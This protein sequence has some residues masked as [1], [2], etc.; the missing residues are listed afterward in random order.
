MAD[1]KLWTI[2]Y[3]HQ[4]ET[5]KLYFYTKN[6][7][8]PFQRNLNVKLSSYVNLYGI[9]AINVKSREKLLILSTGKSCD[10]SLFTRIIWTSPPSLPH[11]RRNLHFPLH[12]CPQRDESIL[13]CLL[14]CDLMSA[15]WLYMLIHGS[16]ESGACMRLTQV[17]LFAL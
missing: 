16:W 9:F 8:T 4:K 2:H 13:W 10:S 11:R 6:N 17:M 12:F 1:G 7:N 3:E 5:Y 15:H 14:S